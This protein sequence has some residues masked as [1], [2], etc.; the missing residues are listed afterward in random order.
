LSPSNDSD[1]LHF[2][3]NK[4]LVAKGLEALFGFF[5]GRGKNG[6]TSQILGVREMQVVM[7][8]KNFP[9]AQWTRQDMVTI[10]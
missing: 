7:Q 1:V 10:S 9:P 4:G 5:M 8:H 3:F 6:K 2:G